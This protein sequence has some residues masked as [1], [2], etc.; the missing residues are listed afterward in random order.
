MGINLNMGRPRK[1]ASLQTGNSTSKAEK[2]RLAQAEQS[3]KGNDD[4]IYDIPEHLDELAIEYY[5]YLIKQLEETELLSNLDK[6]LVEQVADSLSKMRQCD[7]IINRDGILITE[8][9]RAGHENQKEHP[10]ISTKMKYL[11]RFR[12]LSTQLGMS[13]SSRAALAALNIE[14]L[15][16]DSD[17]LLNILNER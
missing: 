13:P 14:K 8:V 7:E 4:M 9:N 2:E 3:L 1:P 5:K 17:Q 6:P 10:I 12:T 16:E 15:E 11:D